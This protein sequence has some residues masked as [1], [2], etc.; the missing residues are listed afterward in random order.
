MKKFLN[1]NYFISATI[2]LLIFLIGLNLYDQYGIS[3]DEDN[4]RENGLIS[5]KYILELLNLNLFDNL[6][7]LSLPQIQEYQ[8][9]GNGVIFDLPLSLLE[10]LLDVNSTREIYLLRHISTFTIFFISLIFFFLIVKNRFNSFTFAI[11]AVLFLFISPRI[12]AQS[13]YNSKDIVFMSLNIINLFFGIKYLKNSNFKNG[14]LFAIFSGISVGL[15]VLGIYLPILICLIK[16]IQILRSKKKIKIQFLKLIV[17]FVL[18]ILSIYIFWPYLWSNPFKNFYN[19]FFKIGNLQVGIY[20]FFLGEYIPVEFPPWNYSFIWI[21]ISTPISYLIL[22]LIGFFYYFR[23][24]IFRILNIDDKSVYKDL[25][26]GEKEMIDFLFFL[27][28]IIP[29]LAIVIMH[30]SIYTGW[31]HLYFIYPS[32][33]FFVVYSIKIFN[34]FFIK[35]LSNIIFLVFLIFTPTTLWMYKNHPFQYVYFNSFFKNNFNKY[36]DMDYWGLSNYHALRYILK[37]NKD[38]E[39][40]IIGFIGTGDLHLSKSFLSDQEK[41]KILITDELEKAEFLIDGYSRWDA[42]KINKK[43]LLEKNLFEVY[44]EIKINKIPINSIYIK[45]PK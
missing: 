44:Y 40:L 19:I 17:V 32:V 22:F 42:M 20:N 18:V 4:S 43:K 9:Q 29:I 24:I 41:K 3:I 23:R 27:N 37:N 13:F 31:R 35:K 30:S 33:I 2:F 15:R 39:S 21:G 6:K 34:I 10:I 1:F 5:L 28:L 14:I 7:D 45:K 36:F 26:R 11:I 25:W 12:F 38:K 8:Q 16:I